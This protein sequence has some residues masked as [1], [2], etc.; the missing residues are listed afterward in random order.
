MYTHRIYT[1]HIYYRYIPFQARP[2]KHG[3][4]HSNK[5]NTKQNNMDI[6]DNQILCKKC[7]KVMKPGLVSKNGFNLRVIKC[8]KCN[9]LIVHPTDKQEYENFIRLKDKE[10]DV[11][12]RMVGNSYSV[13]IPREIVNF[14]KEQ[15]NMINNMVKLSFQEAGRLSLMFNTP[16]MKEENQAQNPNNPSRVVRSRVV[17]IMSNNKPVLHVRQV[18]DSANPKNNQIKVF[19]STKL[20]QEAQEEEDEL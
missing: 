11:K 2:W 15:E 16:E 12:M 6:F 8:E 19:K 17:R 1:K 10:F 7:S 3:R 5:N 14:M 20:N 4:E 13:S 18:S 9:E